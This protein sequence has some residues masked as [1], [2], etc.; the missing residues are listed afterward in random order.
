MENPL[1][2]NTI[3]FVKLRLKNAEAGHDWFHIKRVWKLSKI[4]TEKEG[5]DLE[6]IEFGALLHDIAD[7]KFHNGD[8]ELALKISR[9]FLQNQNLEEKKID[10]ILFIIKH[11]FL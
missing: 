10:K 8:E 9:E 2:L 11:I 5:G 4:I 3:N 1:L 6:I 7:P